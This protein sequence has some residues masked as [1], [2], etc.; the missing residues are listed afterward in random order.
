MNRLTSFA[1]VALWGALAVTLTACG[2][3]TWEPTLHQPTAPPTVGVNRYLKAHLR[4]GEVVLMTLWDVPA[5]GAAT[6]QG[7]GRRYDP[8]RRLLA[9]GCWSIPLDSVS[10][11]ESN[12]QET[13]GR[14]GFTGLVLWSGLNALVAA[15]CLADPKSCFGS[16]PTFYTEEGGSET[17]RAEGFS[18]SI[19]RVLE[20][21]DVDALTGLR[22]VAG[23]VTL[24]MR[25]EAPET[26]AVR[27]VRLLAVPR[28]TAGLPLAVPDGRFLVAGAPV[29][30]SA[31]QSRMGD[32]LAAIGGDDAL[33]YQS[34]ADS[35]DLAAR[36]EL[37]LEFPAVGGPVGLVIEARHTL[38]STF[39]FYQT[40]AWLGQRAGDWLAALEQGGPV[41]ADRAMGLARELGGVE[42]LVADSAGWRVVGIF[43]ESGPIAPDRQVIPLSL[44]T[45]GPIHV[46]LRFAR[47]HFRIGRA[48]LVTLHG[49]EA[50]RAFDPVAV[51]GLRGADPKALARLTDPDHHLVT[52]RGDE[53]RIVFDLSDL[54]GD[55]ELFLE[56]QGYYYEWMRPEWAGEEAPALAALVFADPAAALRHMAPLFK[57]REESMERA[58]W[59]SRF[60]RTVP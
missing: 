48:A 29:E 28:T 9:D 3:H 39:L 15:T 20:A 46:R 7:Q 43:N 59:S 30:P 41:A 52:Q 6:L 53:F 54:Q 44:H 40:I 23:R 45:Q 57:A 1:Q 38:L 60:R 34:P 10:L 2:P 5:P 49:E 36:E 18:A 56:S 14:F 31:C 33:E 19:A 16:C 27:R 51:I 13:V 37:D 12:D 58:F 35:L 11:L 42:V 50:A 24:F 25:N 4:S 21:T 47:G 32:C 26:H 55:H 17:L 8:Y 22:P